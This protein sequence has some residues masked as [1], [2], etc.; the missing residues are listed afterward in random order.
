MKIVWQL[1]F[2]RLLITCL[3]RSAL[4]AHK[5]AQ[6]GLR[7]LATFAVPIWRICVQPCRP[8][9]ASSLQ[10]CAFLDFESPCCPSQASSLCIILT[11]TSPSPSPFVLP[12][13]SLG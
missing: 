12:L 1:M 4:S 6:G 7:V 8:P 11:L 10:R 13:V 3:P 5:Q 2:Q 9:A